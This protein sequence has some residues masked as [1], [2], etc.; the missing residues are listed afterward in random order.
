M[1]IHTQVPAHA[2]ILTIQNLIYTQ[3]KTVSKQRL[4][5]TNEDNSTEQKTWRVY[6]FEKRNVLRF[7]LKGSREGFCQ[8][9]RGRSFHVEEPKTEKAREP[10]CR[11]G[12]RGRP[13]HAEE[14]KTEK[15]REPTVES[16]VRGIWR[17]R[18]SD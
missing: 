18:V 11:R 3:L 14:P 8:T 13:F 12:R 2:S 16:L 1:Y 4:V 10:I 15:A 17:P 7:D 9:G 5:E 6:S